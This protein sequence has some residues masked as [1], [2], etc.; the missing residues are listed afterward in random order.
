MEGGLWLRIGDSWLSLGSQVF[1]SRQDAL[2][3][4][5]SRKENRNIN[6]VGQGVRVVVR[7][8]LLN[9]SLTVTNGASTVFGLCVWMGFS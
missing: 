1:E 4:P 5:L 3:P 8:E 9:A 6:P 2:L 7:V